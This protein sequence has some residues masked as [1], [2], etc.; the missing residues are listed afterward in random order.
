[1]TSKERISK[2]NADKINLI[3]VAK[4]QNHQTTG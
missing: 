3:F 2:M 4:Q 1:M